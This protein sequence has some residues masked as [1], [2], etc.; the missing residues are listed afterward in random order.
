M[1]GANS[2]FTRATVEAVAGRVVH[3]IAG[4]DA[5]PRPDQ[6][7]AVCALLV[8]GRRTLVVQRTGWGKSAVYWIAAKA[9]R[10]AGGGVVLVV[11]PLLALMRNQV[12]S[13]K[14]AGLKA[15]TL[16][17]SNIEDWQAIER[18]VLSNNL[19]I[20]F[21]SPERLANPRFAREVFAVINDRMGLLVIDEAHCISSWGHD[22][23][24][25]YQRIAGLLMANPQ[26][27]VLCT[28]ATANQR[29]TTD[30]AKQLG[31]DTFV[32]RGQLAR[33]SLHLSVVTDLAS[34]QH[35][36]W[37]SEAL[38]TL[39]GSGI[40]YTLTVEKV[41]RLTE[42]LQA[43]D[44]NVAAYYGEVPTE[45]RLRIEDALM[46]NELKAVVATSALGMGYD[47]PD[48]A[49]CL[50]VGCPGSPIDYYQQVGRAGRALDQ[51]TVA[52][53]A[54]Q[55]A[56]R[57]IWEWFATSNVP[58]ANEVDAI[59]RFLRGQG[60]A[61]VTAIAASAAVSR[62]RAE[63]LL[64][65]LAVDGAVERLD[66]SW[67]ALDTN[68]VFDG[69]RYAELV[70]ARRAEANRMAEYAQAS[71][72]LETQL[73]LALD[74]DV[75]P[76]FKC[77]RCSVCTGEL[78]H[79]L[80]SK[81]DKANIV[82]AQRFLRG[83]DHAIE[84]RKRWA[85]GLTI[86]ALPMR[87]TTITAA[88]MSLEG[89]A[90]A[91]GDDAAWADAID[92]LRFDGEPSDELREGIREM[93]QRWRA[94]QAVPPALVVPVPSSRRPRLVA[95]LADCVAREF[96]VPV[97]HALQVRPPAGP[98]GSAIGRPGEMA[99]RITVLSGAGLAN[100]RVLV[101]DDTTLTRWTLTIAG[102]LLREAGAKSVAPL[103]LHQLASADATEG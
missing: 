26:L 38:H 50:H 78:P 47:K 70:L 40:V 80:K 45:E 2:S 44:H 25:D 43:Q 54:D 95:G 82:K 69:A 88:H 14:A 48:L 6:V 39:P 27:P 32:L 63:L 30:V 16:N 85:P 98:R 28:T 87:N 34:A 90:L 61:K 13:A 18:A 77:G 67:R 59:M 46:R 12:E 36:A 10:E 41:K 29:V 66:D 74:D 24:P 72:C 65:I 68:W 101:V 103:V 31:D 86:P 99:Q 71:R 92:L 17:S 60:E 37:V 21:V 76:A 51:A 58:K 5:T 9:V 94:L 33:D 83:V 7:S 19:D 57:R 55:K 79:G 84:P 4:A 15:A 52:L 100:A 23:R 3:A 8:E 64:K 1:S 75:D 22:F 49:F 35:Y 42:F 102:A 62:P 93:L 89:R 73:R 20:L 53:V 81:P 96:G 97:V 56:D 11:S 91:Y